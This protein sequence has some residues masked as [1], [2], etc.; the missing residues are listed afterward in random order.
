VAGRDMAAVYE[1]IDQVGDFWQ[2]ICLSL[3]LFVSGECT[4]Y[5]IS[6]VYSVGKVVSNAN[7]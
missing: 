2:Y 1:I 3:L 5:K 6:R 4:Q 7:A